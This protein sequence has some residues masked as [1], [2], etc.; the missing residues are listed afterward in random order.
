MVT[1]T[2]MKTYFTKLYGKKKAT[3]IMNAA[4]KR[5][6]YIKKHGSYV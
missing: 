5:R 6:A 1:T 2:Q 3:K 4:K